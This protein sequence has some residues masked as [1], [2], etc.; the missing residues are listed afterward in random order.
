MHDVA[1]REAHNEMRFHT[2]GDDKCC[3]PRG[4][5]RATLVN[6]GD[7]L[8]DLA[9]GDVLIFEE[10]LGP[11][12]GQPQDADPTH[13]HAVRLTKA[14]FTNDPLFAEGG[15]P[16][17]VV[18]IEWAPADALPFPLCLWEVPGPD[19]KKQPVSVARGNIVLVD[20][21]GTIAKKETLSVVPAP[22]VSRA[23]SEHAY[24]DETSPALVYPRFRPRLEQGPLTQVGTVLKVD[25]VTRRGERVPFDPEAP[26]AAAFQWD[27]QYARPA[28]HLN[29]E[30]WMP[31]RDLL[32]SGPFEQHFVVETE[33]DGRATLRFGDDR[34]GKRP[35]EGTVFEARY[36]VGNGTRGNVGRGTIQHVVTDEVAETAVTEVRNPLPAR[37]GLDPESRDQVLRSAPSAFRTQER[38]VTADD[39]AAAAERYGGIQRAAATFRWTGS[40]HTVFVTADRL[41]GEPVDETF[42][43]SMRRHLERF[44][45]AGH[46]LEV[47]APSFVSLEIDVRVCVKPEYFRGDVRDALLEVFS[48]RVLA[49]GRRGA[50]HPDNFT[51]GQPVFLSPLYAAAQAVE[52]V[53][54]V[55]ITTFQ[56]QGTPGD[57]GLTLGK[58]AM[59]R[60]EIARLDNDPNF[61]ERG[62]FR[63]TVE[64][65][66]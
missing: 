31:R 18:E 57:E 19:S 55:D 6:D 21:G 7:R 49:A 29:G 36:R 14:E 4:A 8:R 46:D 24:C 52:G 2:W 27:V 53:A 59:G 25:P 63:L 22:T 56:C 32:S 45:M 1:L 35:P 54:S 3:L 12:T 26:A 17:R 41:G 16:L 5:V 50:F 34:H 47:D 10:V 9:R 20:H 66:K 30:Q 23:V 61:P 28:V 43:D 48:N 62:V 42:E 64:G 51:F 13:R 60:L 38:A 58:L 40:W 44:R 33:D 39:Y 15:Q 11:T 37:G 65:G